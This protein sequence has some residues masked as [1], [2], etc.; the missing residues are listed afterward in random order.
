MSAAHQRMPLTEVAAACR[1]QACKR[2]LQKAFRIEGYSCRV[3]PKKP[4]LDERKRGLR[5]AFAPAH[6]GWSKDDWR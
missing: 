5:L 1:V 3:A 6:R 4:F 2:T